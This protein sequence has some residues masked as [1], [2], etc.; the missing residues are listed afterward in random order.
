VEGPDG[1]PNNEREITEPVN[2]RD[3]SRQVRRYAGAQPA[4]FGERARRPRMT[5]GRTI[6]Q[7]YWKVTNTV[8]LLSIV[9]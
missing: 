8:L 1:T 5:A 4:E 2:V 9:T 7:C 3:Q 6:T